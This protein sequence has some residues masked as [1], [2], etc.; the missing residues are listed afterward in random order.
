MTYA[1]RNLAA[2]RV[3][4]Q[5]NRLTVTFSVVRGMFDFSANKEFG[6]EIAL[7][8]LLVNALSSPME[9]SRSIAFADPNGNPIPVCSPC[10]KTNGSEDV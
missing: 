5:P 3:V 8:V 6:V 10:A 2:A 4:N 7:Q 1:A 9:E